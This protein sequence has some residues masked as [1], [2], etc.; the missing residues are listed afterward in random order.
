ML[1]HLAFKL[2]GPLT[3]LFEL[4]DGSSLSE[5]DSHKIFLQLVKIIS[6]LL[7]FTRSQW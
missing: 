4:G 5:S 3:S 6:E 2:H 7:P 1:S